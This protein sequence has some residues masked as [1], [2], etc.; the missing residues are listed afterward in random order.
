MLLRAWNKSFIIWFILKSSLKN[1]IQDIRMNCRSY[2]A[3]FIFHVILLASYLA[4]NN[5]ILFKFRVAQIMH[6]CFLQ[7]VKKMNMEKKAFCVSS[8]A[9]VVIWGSYEVCYWH[10]YPLCC[11]T[12]WSSYFVT[13]KMRKSLKALRTDNP[14]DPAIGTRLVQQTS[15]TLPKM[16]IQSNRLNA[17][18]K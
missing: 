6:F 2:Y 1:N 16:T 18:S 7:V 5:M 11:T 10:L 15:T 12:F 13:L 14:N 17:D 9:N 4:S 3:S 8:S